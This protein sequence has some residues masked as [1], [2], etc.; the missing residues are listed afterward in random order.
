MI[1]NEDIQFVKG[2]RDSS[3]IIRKKILFRKNVNYDPD[4]VMK[5]T[6]SETTDI[7]L[8]KLS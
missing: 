7:T 4:V 6:C 1:K 8:K 5:N 3:G 2:I